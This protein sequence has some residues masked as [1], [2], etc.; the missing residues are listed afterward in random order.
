MQYT[1]LQSFF[2]ER[3]IEL[4]HKNTLD[5]Y[6]VRTHNAYTL[7]KELQEL[8]IDWGNNQIK[9]FETIKLCLEETKEAISKDTCLSYPYYSKTIFIQ[10]LDTC[11]KNGDKDISKSKRLIMLLHNCVNYNKDKYLQKLFESIE[12][13]LFKEGA[14]EEDN[15]M[16]ETELLDAYVSDLCRQ[17]LYIG[18]SKVHLYVYLSSLDYKSNFKDT[19]ISLKNKFL[20]SEE[21]DFIVVFKLLFPETAIKDGEKNREC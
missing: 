20:F 19:Y 14:L 18:Y 12:S 11:I 15:F 8:L 9:Q 13:I 1:D 21:K 3:F 7:L 6:R 5:S 17:L 16:K 10:E 4:L 2:V